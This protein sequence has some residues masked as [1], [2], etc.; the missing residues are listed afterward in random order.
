MSLTDEQRAQVIAFHESR[1]NAVKI[2][3]KFNVHPST[4]GRIIAKFKKTGVYT[5]TKQSGRPKKLSKMD[6]RQ[7]EDLVIHERRGNLEDFRK[8]MRVEVSVSTLRRAL[9]ELGIFCRVA[10]KK[11]HLSPKQIVNRLAFAKKY[12]DWTVEQWRKVLWTD[13][14]SFERGKATRRAH[15]WRRN[16]E[17]NNLDCLA[18]TFK[19]GR[20]SV[21]VWGG[22]MHGKK[23]DL[24][25]FEQKV[26]KTAVYYRD[27][28]Y[29]GPL[30]RFME[31]TRDFLLM[32]D[33]APIHRSNAPLFWRQ[34]NGVEKIMDWPAQ[35][36]DLNPIENLWY[37]MKL[38]V[39]LKA[40][41]MM[42]YADFTEVIQSAWDSITPENFNHLIDSMP[43]RMQA[44]IDAKGAST[45]W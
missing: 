23:T 36:P 19:S 12:K 10:R 14:A 5:K 35:S 3:T 43:R 1:W 27:R 45:R 13:E 40:N 2:A 33:G 37:K 18:A 29:K 24:A 20:I 6:V 15:S 41:N 7:L 42:M 30:L 17:A 9:H 11:P 38:V 31:G 22:I 26:Q 16:E 32:E 44:V 28:V 4:I 34:E 25:V 8:L 39:N 21:M